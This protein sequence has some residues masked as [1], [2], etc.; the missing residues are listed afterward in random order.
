M[1]K[2]GEHEIEKSGVGMG[3]G[4]V[5]I[6]MPSTPGGYKENCTHWVHARVRRAALG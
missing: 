2:A 1:G 3:R 4:D 6:E 5:A